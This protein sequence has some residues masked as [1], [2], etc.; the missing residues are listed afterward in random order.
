MLKYS[1]LAAAL[2]MACGIAAAAPN[3][4]APASFAGNV[5]SIDQVATA[6]FSALDLKT[7]GEED[8]LREASGR[9]MRFAIAH[10]SAVNVQSGGS[11]EQHG[12]RS[13]WRYRVQAD[14]ATSLNFGFTRFHVP[15]SARLYIYDNKDHA[16]LAGP[17]DAVSHNAL[18]QL[19]TPIIAPT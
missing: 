3:A 2:T 13:I 5:K 4:N 9:P 17:Y 15:A 1:Y 10:D 19:W 16:Q 14:A 18:G 7:I 11:W 8:A 6:R 12:E